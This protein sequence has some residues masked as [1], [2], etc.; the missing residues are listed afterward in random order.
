MQSIIYEDDFDSWNSVLTVAE[1]LGIKELIEESDELKGEEAVK[2]LA[3]KSLQ[4]LFL[5]KYYFQKAQIGLNN[6]LA[7]AQTYQ[8]NEEGLVYYYYI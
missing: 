1:G 6:L 3:E 7:Q 5:D 8:L 2:L 4:K